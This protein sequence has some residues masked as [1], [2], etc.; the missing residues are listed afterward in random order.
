VLNTLRPELTP[1][2]AK[3]L[4]HAAI[5]SIH[6]ILRHRSGLD[7][8]EIASILQDTA[9]HILGVEPG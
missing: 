5:S 4:V 7:A 3:V 2:H 8:P 1:Q 6:S 9:V